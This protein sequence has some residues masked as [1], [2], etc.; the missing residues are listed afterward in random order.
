MTVRISK[1]CR[2]IMDKAEAA[3]DINTR[4]KTI[5]TSGFIPFFLR[6][7]KNRYFCRGFHTSGYHAEK[8]GRISKKKITI[9][10]FLH[11]VP[12]AGG[13]IR[14]VSLVRMIDTQ[15]GIEIIRV[16]I[17]GL[18]SCFRTINHFHIQIKY[19]GNPSAIPNIINALII[20]GI[21]NL[22]FHQL[23][24][25]AGAGG[26]LRSFPRLVQRREQH[27]CQNSNDG[28]NHKQLY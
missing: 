13:T 20:A 27:A 14:L 6:I 21:Q 23:I 1:I 10:F 7:S 2:L 28:Y 19:L 16:V 25:L 4:F 15:R 5:D 24:Q 9:R 22:R 26:F 17:G 12:V 3:T 11:C 8:R 18:R